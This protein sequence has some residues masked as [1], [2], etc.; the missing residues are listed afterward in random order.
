[1]RNLG[2]R[3]LN[4]QC[5]NQWSMTTY[6]GDDGV[7]FKIDW[8]FTEQLHPYEFQIIQSDLGGYHN[9]VVCIEPSLDQP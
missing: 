8:M 4:A 3:W 7:Y 5:L 2:L 1:M 9:V 6:F